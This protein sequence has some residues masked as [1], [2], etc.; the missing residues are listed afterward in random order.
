MAGIE[1]RMGGIVFVDLV[2][3]VL[4][5]I[6]QK[7]ET[8][9]DL[10]FV[11]A[12][13]A[14]GALIDQKRF[15]DTA[16][17]AF[18]HGGI[19]DERL[20]DQIANRQADQCPVPVAHFHRMKRDLR[21]NAVDLLPVKNAAE[22]LGLHDDPVADLDQMVG[23]DLHAGDKGVDR[24]LKKKQQYRRDRAQPGKQVD[25]AFFDQHRN[26]NDDRGHPYEADRDPEQTVDGTLLGIVLLLVP[27][28]ETLD[29]VC[30]R[31]GKESDPDPP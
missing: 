8:L 19:I 6:L 18:F 29:G 28:A 26:E 14:D 11:H 3:S 7:I 15:F 5:I 30:R 17:A 25:R 23:V 2:L 20:V 24:V 13:E 27:Q 10:D 1:S 31:H 9:E 4:E 22:R 16:A 12:Q 21:D